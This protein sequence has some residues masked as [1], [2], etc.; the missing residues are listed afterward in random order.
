MN[1]N[2]RL[3]LHLKEIIDDIDMQCFASSVTFWEIAIKISLGKLNLDIPFEELENWTLKNKIGIL[4]LDFKHTLQLSKL[5]FHH[6]DPFDRTLISQALVEDLTLISK[7]ELFDN[8]G[9][10]R[11]W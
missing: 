7:E 8:Y 11:L 1:A 10:K 6:R 4:S 2:P 5:P 3:P 9:V